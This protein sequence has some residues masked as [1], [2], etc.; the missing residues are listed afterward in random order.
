MKNHT[1]SIIGAGP[2]G[3]AAAIQLKR[4]D[5]NPVI[6]EKETIGGLLKNA[7][8]IENYPG[9]PDGISSTN[10]IKLFKKHLK[11]SNIKIEYEK[12]FELNYKHDFFILKTLK[13][14]I[15]SPVV[16]IASGTKPIKI[17]DFSFPDEIK[18]KI[19]YDIYP[20]LKIRGEKITIIGAGDAAFDYAINMSKYNSVTILNRSKKIRALHV[21]NIRAQNV[22]NITY[23]DNIKIKEIKKNNNRLRLIC[24]N[25]QNKM[26]IKI[27]DTS[28]IVAAIGRIP[29][30]DFLSS[31]LKK[32]KNELEIKG[33]LH[34]IGDVK[35]S[36]FRQTAIAIADGIKSSIKI[37][38]LLNKN[39]L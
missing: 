8:L 13:K 15:T 35:N 3:I 25:L 2:A 7:N 23:F 34:I 6:F 9:F 16:I 17:T 21:L 22:K 33:I 24:Y 5:I 27:I 28:Y 30:L 37:H 12:I 20:L 18:N 29:N 10:L 26:E 39:S 36:M 32:I 31:E 4:Y 19:Y 14:T 1:V 11:N 38:E